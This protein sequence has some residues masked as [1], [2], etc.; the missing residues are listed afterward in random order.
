MDSPILIAFIT[1]LVWCAAL[2]VAVFR[3]TAAGF[4]TKMLALW[5]EQTAKFW[6]HTGGMAGTSNR[7]AELEEIT[8]VLSDR[9]KS[10]QGQI[11]AMKSGRGSKS[12]PKETPITVENEAEEWAKMM[13]EEAIE[14]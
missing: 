13:S 6:E 7:I 11:S 9:L 12:K 5:D 1:V 10:Q 8:T 4:R 14:S 2:T 3:S